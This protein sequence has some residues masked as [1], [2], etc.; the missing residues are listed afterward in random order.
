MRVGYARVSW[1]DQNLQSQLDRLSDC[2]KVFAEKGYSLDADRPAL[3]ECLNFVRQG[4]VLVCTR[5]DRLARSVHHLCGIMDT[6]DRRGV[7]LVVLD[8]QLD[9]RTPTGRLL[10]HLL[11]AIA[12]FEMAIRQERQRDGYAAAR[13]RGKRFGN[14][15]KLSPTQAIELRQLRMAGMSILALQERFH[16]KRSTVYKYLAGVRPEPETTP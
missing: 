4:D 8:Q 9:T 13:A 5:L 3:V 10:F 1:Q 7:N 15:F 6:L 12:E 11:A 2:E 14:E 16:L